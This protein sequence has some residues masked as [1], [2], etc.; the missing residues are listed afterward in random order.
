MCRIIGKLIEHKNFWHCCGKY[1][2]LQMLQTLK[3]VL[4][5]YHKETDTPKSI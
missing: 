4:Y 3:F 1:F 2:Y 5:F